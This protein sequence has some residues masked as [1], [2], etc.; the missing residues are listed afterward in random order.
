VNS[1]TQ[2]NGRSC[3]VVVGARRARSRVWVAARVG[4]SI[5]VVALVPSGIAAGVL[6]ALLLPRVQGAG[7]R[8]G[9]EREK[10]GGTGWV[11]HARERRGERSKQGRRR[12]AWE[13]GARG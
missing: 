4:A 1:I 8:K 7:G 9:R 13:L 6:A 5:C 3:G 10:K 2:G 11:P 12:L